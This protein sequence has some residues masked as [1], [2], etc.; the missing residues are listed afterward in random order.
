MKCGKNMCKSR[1]QGTTASRER[2]TGEARNIKKERR[3]RSFARSRL[4]PG[5]EPVHSSPLFGKQI[6]R[7]EYIWISRQ[8]QD[9][10]MRLR[11]LLTGRVIQS[12]R[13]RRTIA[14]EPDAIS[15][16]TRVEASG[17]SPWRR[18][19]KHTSRPLRAAQWKEKHC[20]S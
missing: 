5:D 10:L 2:L 3:L 8:E 15:I 17:G 12:V 20:S 9:C 18:C 19:D 4:F 16:S 14:M 7:G 11:S 13:F 6:S 1:K